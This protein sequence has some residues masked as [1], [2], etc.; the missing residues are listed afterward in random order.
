MWKC[1]RDMER[2]CRGLIPSIVV[3]IVDESGEPCSSPSAQYQ[4]WRRHFITVLNIRS[5]YDTTAMDE[6][7]QRKV[8]EDLGQAHS[9]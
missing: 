8:D 7:R 4:H 6:V 3:T 1:I 9:S 2:G 5:Q